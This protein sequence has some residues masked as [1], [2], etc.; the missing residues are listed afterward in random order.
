M[1]LR[2]N[3]AGVNLL[4]V[5]YARIFQPHIRMPSALILHSQSRQH[6]VVSRV[7]VRYA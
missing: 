4:T 1:R 5:A 6:T 7:M 2:T 3:F